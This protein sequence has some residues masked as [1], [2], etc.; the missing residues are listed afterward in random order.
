[1]GIALQPGKTGIF[2]YPAS[3]G[4]ADRTAAG[5]LGIFPK[6]GFA[7]G[8]EA[9]EGGNE[10]LNLFTQRL[11]LVRGVLHHTGILLGDFVHVD[12][13]GAD[14]PEATRLAFGCRGN[15]RCGR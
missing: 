7:A 8:A 11:R 12:Y 4:P 2:R 15:A 9:P 13:R 10:P 6:A 14:L 1:M 5:I 3:A